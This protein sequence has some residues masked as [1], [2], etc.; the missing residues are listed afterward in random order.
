MVV[1]GR[2]GRKCH[3]VGAHEGIALTDGLVCVQIS[4]SLQSW[5][6]VKALSFVHA[7]RTM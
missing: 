4:E 1:A 7:S 5:C 2:S 6:A 3:R